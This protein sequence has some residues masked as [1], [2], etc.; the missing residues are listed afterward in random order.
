MGK[1]HNFSSCLQILEKRG[2]YM[3]AQ[4]KEIEKNHHNHHVQLL[5]NILS[6]KMEQISRPIT[7]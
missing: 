3:K 6:L 1:E 7:L 5:L 2:A 4:I